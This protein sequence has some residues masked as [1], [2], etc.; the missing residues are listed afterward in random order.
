M[1]ASLPVV[2]LDDESFRNTVIDGLT[3]YLFKNKKEY[4]NRVNELISDKKKR[5]NMGN[6]G[7]INSEVYSSKY[8]A[9]RVLHVYKLAL[10]GRPLKKDKSFFARLKSTV[11]RGFHGK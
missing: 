7:R 11:K 3:G 6:Q 4:I 10:K 8:F 9:E 2:A 5:E 1:A